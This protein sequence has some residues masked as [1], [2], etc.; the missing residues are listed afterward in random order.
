[1]QSVISLLG[2]KANAKSRDS[3]FFAKIDLDGDHIHTETL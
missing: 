3:T 2:L 1:M